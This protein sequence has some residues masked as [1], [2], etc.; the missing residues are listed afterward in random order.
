MHDLAV[1]MSVYKNDRLDFVKASIQSI[2]DQS[3]S[4]FDYFISFDGFVSAEIDNYV[5]SLTD[6][7]IRFFR[8]KNNQGLASVLNFML[9]IIMAGTNY[10]YIARMDADDVS[11]NERFVRQRDFLIANPAIACVGSWYEEID[12]DNQHLFYRQLPV[13]STSL[14]RRY[15]TM[16][17]FAHSSVMFRRELIEKAG[18]YPTNTFRME[19]NLLWGRALSAGLKFANIPEYLL[20]FRI[21]KNFYKRRSGIKYGWNFLKTKLVINRLL[22]VPITIYLYSILS[23]LMKLAPQFVIRFLYHLPRKDYKLY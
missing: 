3:F 8:M 2:L 17:P 18:Y 6:D 21:D 16:A 20:Q 19:D 15:F 14:K 10:R 5:T 1:L 9:E 12:E 23:S 22:K 7:R 13:D 11:K 4:E